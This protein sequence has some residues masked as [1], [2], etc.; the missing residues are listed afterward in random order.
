MSKRTL[1]VLLSCFVIFLLVACCCVFFAGL[2]YLPAT[3]DNGLTTNVVQPGDETQ[4]VA[5]IEV[6][7]VITNQ[8]LTDIWGQESPSMTDEI[9]QKI[10]AAEKDDN[11][12]AI[13]MQVNSP[14]GEALASKIIHNRLN[15]FKSSGKTLVVQMQDIAASGGYLISVPADEIVASNI[16]T[17]GSIG[18]IVS[19]VDFA[20]LYEK[21]GIR[22]FTVV[23][24]EG[25]LKVLQGLGDESSESHK[26]LKSILDDVYDDFVNIVAQG[27]NM[28]KSQV[29]EHAD[30]RIYSGKQ[31][32]DIG[33]VD[34]LGEMETAQ[35]SVSTLAGLDNPRYITYSTPEN[36]FS[37]YSLSL[38]KILFPEL[39]AVEAKKPGITVEYLMKF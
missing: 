16:T 33:L 14:G 35:Q 32:K 39:A 27:R 4:T 12:K 23:N 11:V 22:E 29:R 6:N 18:V 31:A 3:V 20:G 36:P 10:N 19:G 9:L 34:T 30:G 7:G 25:D 37:L 5:I 17:T 24:T 2:S 38:K 13:L 8:T 28:T 1:K 21:L 15:D 26:I